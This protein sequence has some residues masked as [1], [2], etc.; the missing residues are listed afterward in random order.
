MIKRTRIISFRRAKAARKP[1]SCT[2]SATIRYM[3]P[4]RIPNSQRRS[5]RS[6]PSSGT[7]PCRNSSHGSKASTRV[8]P[9]RPS[10]PGKQ[11]VP[12]EGANRN[13]VGLRKARERPNPSAGSETGRQA[14]QRIGDDAF[15][16]GRAL[17]QTVRQR[18]RFQ[19]RTACAASISHRVVGG[20]YR[21]ADTPSTKRAAIAT[22]KL[23]VR[24]VIRLAIAKPMMA[25]SRSGR[26][27]QLR[28]P[29]R[30]RFPAPRP[31]PG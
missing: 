30:P 15:E 11:P 12:V 22:I 13:N 17:R 20:K 23:A 10:H 2:G 27:R 26:L 3:R 29:R 7:L 8:F 19:G 31:R 1:S 6:T 4:S 16:D 21:P 24:A 9:I 14:D 25:P 18:V 28:S 5:Q